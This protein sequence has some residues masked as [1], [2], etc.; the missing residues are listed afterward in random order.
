[1][2]LECVSKIF[3]NVFKKLGCVIVSI[4]FLRIEH[5]N[6][7]ARC[8]NVAYVAS[9]CIHLVSLSMSAVDVFRSG[10]LRFLLLLD[11]LRLFVPLLCGMS[12]SLRLYDTYG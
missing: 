5:V 3:W 9:D 12:G 2:P 4:I 11:S 10:F 8:V 1:M 7:S 6:Y